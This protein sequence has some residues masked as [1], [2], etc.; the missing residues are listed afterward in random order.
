MIVSLVWARK[1]AVLGLWT[2]SFCFSFSFIINQMTIEYIL[3]T[4]EYNRV[5]ID[6]Q[7]RS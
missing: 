6:G 1:D 3:M 5:Y 7:I 4:I 2:A